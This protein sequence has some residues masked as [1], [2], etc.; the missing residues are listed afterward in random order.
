[1]VE[2][3]IQVFSVSELSEF[4]LEHAYD[5]WAQNSEYPFADENRDTLK[6][7]CQ[8]FPVRVQSM[9]YGDRNEI[10]WTFTETPEIQDL[11]SHRLATYIWNNF[12]E[13]SKGKYYSKSKWENGQY[14]YKS[15][16]SHVM[17]DHSCVLTGYC[18]D[19]TIM[20][21]IYAFLEAPD[22]RDFWDLMNDCLCEFIFACG[23]DY[24]YYFS[25]KNFIEEAETNEYLY[26]ADGRRFFS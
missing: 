15:R 22:R 14:N 26:T 19:D 20:S 17:L 24:D 8:I 4:A 3:K 5:R 6:A 11:S 18:M 7:F 1:M 23:R 10:D 25:L 16:H 9:G 13:I 12:P 21:P 2:K